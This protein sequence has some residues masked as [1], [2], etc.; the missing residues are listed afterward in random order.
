MIAYPI[1][2]WY[3]VSAANVSIEVSNGK[4]SDF[5]TL[6]SARG[7]ASDKAARGVFAIGIPDDFRTEGTALKGRL[8][9]G[10]Y[11][12]VKA[13]AS[14]GKPTL[15]RGDWVDREILPS[16]PMESGKYVTSKGKIVNRQWV[17]EQLKC[18][19]GNATRAA[20]N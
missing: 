3:R 13:T 10:F 18:E 1:C 20:R 6:W 14:D 5:K 15:S 7:A 9:K 16:P 2:P 4:K 11:V 19:K 8:P 17:N 12:S